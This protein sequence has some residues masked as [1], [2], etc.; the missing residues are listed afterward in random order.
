MLVFMILLRG[1]IDIIKSIVIHDTKRHNKT[2]CQYKTSDIKYPH[3]LMHEDQYRHK[4]HVRQDDIGNIYALLRLQC[5]QNSNYK[6]KQ[7]NRYN[8]S[9]SVINID[10][11]ASK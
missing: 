10:E 6:N 5:R 8:Q 7:W 9:I 11:V 1:A 2:T 4:S 3:H